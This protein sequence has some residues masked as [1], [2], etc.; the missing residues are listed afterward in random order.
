MPLH[1][2]TPMDLPQERTKPTFIVRRLRN[3]SLCLKTTLS[4]PATSFFKSMRLSKGSPRI[5]PNHSTPIK[6]P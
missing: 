4:D 6:V 3:K 5:L 2:L 1:K